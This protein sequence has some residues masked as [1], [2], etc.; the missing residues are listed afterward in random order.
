MRFNRMNKNLTNLELNKNAI[1]ISLNQDTLKA[2]Y[3]LELID[4][5]FLPGTKINVIQKF[6][7]Q[8][9]IIVKIGKVYLSLRM[10]DAENILV[11]TND[12]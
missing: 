4:F 6:P 11:E 3:I 8:N 2:D 5:G 10:N 12:G 7:S 9:K 1:I